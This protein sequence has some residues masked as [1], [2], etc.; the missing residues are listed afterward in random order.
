M[1]KQDEIDLAGKLGEFTAIIRGLGDKLDAIESDLKDN[2][3]VL[4]D[5]AKTVR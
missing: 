4:N 3:K 2:G 5:M 1:N